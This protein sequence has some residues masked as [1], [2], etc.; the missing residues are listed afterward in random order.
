MDTPM[1]HTD[2]ESDD[3]DWTSDDRE[4]SELDDVDFPGLPDT[5]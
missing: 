2:Y 1:Y 3:Y 4:W 5:H